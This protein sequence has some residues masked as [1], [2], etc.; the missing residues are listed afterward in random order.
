MKLSLLLLL[1]T[2]PFLIQCSTAEK[3]NV[4][5]AKGAY[6]QAKD[7]QNDERF[8]EAIAGFQ[9]VRNKFPY[10]HFVKKSEISIAEIYFQREDFLE[11]QHA[12]QLYKDLHPKDKII[13]AVTY[14]L[15]LS[16]FKQ[17]PDSI[18]RDLSLAHEAILYFE[19]VIDSHPTSKYVK[20]SKQYRIDCFKK[21]TQKEYYVAQ[22]YYKQKKFLSALGRYE[23]IVNK[24]SIYGYNPRALKGAILSAMKINQ[25]ERAKKHFKTLL[26]THSKTSEA[27]EIKEEFYNELK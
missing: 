4:N 11:A 14:Q 15:A 17:L 16:I 18:D 27:S 3:F 1:L 9:E 24:Y 25:K 12:Y 5:T 7:L 6:E 20:N 21:L 8:E 10:S 13:D 2:I 23:N 22:Y 19:E 26:S